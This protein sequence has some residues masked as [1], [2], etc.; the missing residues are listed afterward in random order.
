MTLYPALEMPRTGN[1]EH[2]TRA[3]LVKI[4]NLLESWIR[5]RP[6]QWLWIHHRWG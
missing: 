3:M 1:Q 4:N 6:E 2:D 5:A